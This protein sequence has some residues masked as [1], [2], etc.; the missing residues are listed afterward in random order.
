M[1]EYLSATRFPLT[2]QHGLDLQQQKMIDAHNLD[3][4]EHLLQTKAKPLSER[5]NKILAE[6]REKQKL[7]EA[8]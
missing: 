1:D 5:Q 7:R 8:A 6:L 4:L 2:T 3:E